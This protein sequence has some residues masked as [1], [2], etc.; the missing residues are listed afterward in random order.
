MNTRRSQR[1]GGAAPAPEASWI[2]SP[3]GGA[4]W[5]DGF[6][7][8]TGDRVRSRMDGTEAAIRYGVGGSQARAATG[9][10]FEWRH[11]DCNVLQG[12]HC[13]RKWIGW[14]YRHPDVMP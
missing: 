12:G 10:R 11:V 5:I 7:N 6:C 14:V 4:W 1:S 3:R 2:S 8:Y 9:T 13:D